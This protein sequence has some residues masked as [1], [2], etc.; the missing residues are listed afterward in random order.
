MTDKPASSAPE[1]VLPF[2]AEGTPLRRVSALSEAKT[3]G[4]GM[5]RAVLVA[6]DVVADR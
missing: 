2:P 4:A 1:I 6:G 3:G 5:Q